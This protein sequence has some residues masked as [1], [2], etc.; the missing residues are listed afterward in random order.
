M[1]AVG[2]QSADRGPGVAAVPRQGSGDIIEPL[3]AFLDVGS[4]LCGRHGS[5]FPVHARS[6]CSMTISDGGRIADECS[7]YVLVM[8]RVNTCCGR[9]ANRNRLAR[10]ET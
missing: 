4:D 7:Y 10:V 1:F 2:K 8:R 3:I 6:Y 9:L 5:S